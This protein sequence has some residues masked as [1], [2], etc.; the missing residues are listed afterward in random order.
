MM[1]AW[2]G[3]EIALPLLP[4]VLAAILVLL[5]GVSALPQQR[6]SAQEAGGQHLL[7]IALLGLM[8]CVWLL[9]AAPLV[10][11]GSHGLG[12]A[13]VHDGIS[14]VF[15]TIIC[16][17]SALSVALALPYLQAHSLAV[18]EYVSL[19]LLSTT[20]G[21][22]V[23]MAGDLLTLFLG[24]ELM[25]MAAYVLAGYR[26]AQRRTQEAALKYYFYGAFASAFMVFGIALL[27]GEGGLALGEPTFSLAG[28]A[29]AIDSGLLRPLGWVGAGLLTSGLLFKVGAVP[30]HMWTPDVYQG[31][32]TPSSAFFSA[33]IKTASFAG[34]IRVLAATLLA[35]KQTHSCA[36]L[37]EVLALASIIVGNL[38]AVRQTQLKRLLAYSSVA[39]AG[40][41]LLGL[42]AFVAQPQG[43]GLPA[44]A[45]Y[46][47]S[48]GAMSIGTFGIVLALEPS[49]ERRADFAID[50]LTG[51]A[52]Q[53]PFLG[54]VAAIC[55]FAL[56]GMPPTAGFFGK[57][58]LLSAC[59][60][61]EHTLVACIA[62]LASAI[63]AYAY[64]K[65]LAVM[66]MRPMA[67]EVPRLQAAWLSWALALSAGLTVY[68]GV[69]PEA[70]FVWAR[71]AL[72][73]WLG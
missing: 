46:L 32:P 24:I 29:A 42:V 39:H 20:G 47:L 68:W 6:S 13:L 55:F 8:A 34:L 48:Y 36:A 44:L 31:A 70:T 65:V 4:L 1:P 28:I 43:D 12:S 14:L 17:S 40:Y 71:Q 26:R 51:V 59:V 64:L 73:H 53:Q 49:S 52:R 11:G 61:A 7:V 57:F 72:Q 62:A 5:L 22:M 60:R 63:G 66:F 18:G 54:A 19:L 69:A 33:T 3:G 38:L 27:W 9:W 37:L 21:L 2:I 45:F 41:A 58:A 67:N 25:S 35:S 23:A 50:R 56:A 10:P 16:A 15:G 30:F